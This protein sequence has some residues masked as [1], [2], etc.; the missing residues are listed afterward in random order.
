MK[1]TDGWLDGVRHIHSPNFNERPAHAVVD[2][3][4]IHNISLPPEQFN[5]SNIELFFQNKLPW[6]A[7]PYFSTIQGLEVS[8]HF[9]VKRC[10]EII[11]FVSCDKRAWHAGASSFCGQENCN[12]FSIGIELEGADEIEYEVIQYQKLAELTLILSNKYFKLN[13]SR[14]VGHCDIAPGRKTD[15]GISFDWN[16]YKKQMI[17]VKI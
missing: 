5:N 4:V 8:S 1:F 15:P 14:I 12:D 10:G 2:L 6:D 17:I 9:L 13:W 7:H 11:Q 16:I 3:L